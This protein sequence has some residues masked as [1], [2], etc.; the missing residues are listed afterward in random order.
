MASPRMGRGELGLANVWYRRRRPVAV[1]LAGLPLH[2]AP[3]VPAEVP[4]AE[5]AVIGVSVGDCRAELTVPAAVV[6][7]LLHALGVPSTAALSQLS[8]LLA[9]EFAG[10]SWLDAMEQKVGL[11]I[12]LTDYRMAAPIASPQALA[13][14]GTL[15]GQAFAAWLAWPP[16]RVGVL[17]ALLGPPR[18]IIDCEI[19]IDVALRIGT[20]RLPLRLVEGL[21]PGDVIIL[22]CTVFAD[23]RVAVVCGERRL[24]FASLDGSCATLLTRP[25]PFKGDTHNAWS[26]T[27]STM[28]NDDR[29]T[30][31]DLDDIRVKL[32]FEVGRLE[33]PL[34]ELRT[35][36]PGHVFE[37]GR[38]PRA[39]VE[40]V[41]GARRIGYG[42][43]VQIGDALGVRVVRIFNRD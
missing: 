3:A 19:A 17:A 29:A 37:L 27:D 7:Q 6:D 32:L 4:S 22:D 11:P 18:P 24:A 5:S 23:G 30:D 14:A 26:E 16:Q 2:A 8:T 25:L 33:I 12:A 13:L 10:A 42:E 20:T 31:A 28:S 21:A 43:V 40:I 34:G 38:D 9:L 41:T 35:L 1:E 39:A 15:A 36:A